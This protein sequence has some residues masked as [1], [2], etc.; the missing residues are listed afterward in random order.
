VEPNAEVV[1][2]DDNSPDGTGII[3]NKIA[4]SCPEVKVI[5]RSHKLGVG[6][7]VYEGVRNAKSDL[8]VVMDSD[9][10][11]PV[12]VLPKIKE[13]LSRGHDVVIASRYVKGSQFLCSSVSRQIINKLGNKVARRLLG[14]KVKDCTHGFRGY[15]KAVFL[16]SFDESFVDG[17]FNLVV[18][19]NAWKRG[20]RI[21]EVPCHI[22]HPGKSNS[23]AAL[24]YLVALI[25]SR[26]LVRRRSAAR[27]R[28]RETCK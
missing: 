8:V 13:L 18:L 15:K 10:H 4:A 16:D 5:H 3:A 1:I 17:S 7:A 21:A 24:R 9:L 20:Y 23:S 22:V 26:R 19:A 27:L 11:N 28:D 12:S 14:V 2:V 25:A 6:S